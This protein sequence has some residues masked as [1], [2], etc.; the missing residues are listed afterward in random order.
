MRELSIPQIKSLF[1][2]SGEPTAQGYDLDELRWRMYQWRKLGLMYFSERLDRLEKA[3]TIDACFAVEP[4][5][6]NRRHASNRYDTS[7]DFVPEP[8]PILAEVYDALQEKY[9]WDR[10][11]FLSE[12]ATLK[13]AHEL[14]RMPTEIVP[15]SDE[16]ERYR[17]F[18]D[19]Y[20]DLDRPFRGTRVYWILFDEQ[21]VEFFSVAFRLDPERLQKFMVRS[22][23]VARRRSKRW[24][25]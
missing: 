2:Y 4:R 3:G 10:V 23:H 21:G 24:Q 12:L 15:D 22:N 18:I 5:G 6:T 1:A 14:Q 16:Y 19:R 8:F 9:Q 11:A 7:D 20:Y 25:N 13:L 17:F